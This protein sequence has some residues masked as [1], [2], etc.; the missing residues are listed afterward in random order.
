LTTA[1]ERLLKAAES[2][3]P[4]GVSSALQEGADVNAKDQYNNTALNSAALFGHGEVVKTLLEAGADIE[5]RGSGGGLTPLANA[6][7]RRHFAI[8][9][10]L[11]DRGARVTDDLLSVLQ[12]KLN[13]LQENCEA[14]MVTQEAV[15]VWKQVMQIFITQRQK[16]DLP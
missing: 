15:D 2:G 16:Q 1:N 4:V 12:T 7:S 9:Q 3:D 8:A 11:L 13:I 14:G 5:N 10:T 6:A